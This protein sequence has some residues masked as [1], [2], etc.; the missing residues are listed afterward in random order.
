MDFM[1]KRGFLALKTI[2][3]IAMAVFVLVATSYIAKEFGTAEIYRKEVAAK[4]IALTLDVLY[5]YPYDTVVYYDKDMTGMIV[6]VAGNKVIIYDS[7]FSSSS[8]DPTS[9]K[10][11]FS[12]AGSNPLKARIANPKILKFEKI[13]GKIGVSA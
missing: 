4:E 2:I 6:E 7:R 3:T 12:Q 13:G 5:A 9:R 8:L 1:A 10:Y 11:D